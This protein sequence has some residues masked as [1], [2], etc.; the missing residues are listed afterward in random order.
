MRTD[1]LQV[2][3]S[4]LND[5]QE[6]LS[7]KLVAKKGV[8]FYIIPVMNISYF[9]CENR[10]TYLKDLSG[11]K[12][13]IEKPLIELESDLGKLQFL[14]VAKNILLNINHILK[15]KSLEAGK[16]EVFTIDNSPIIVS[17]FYAAT[18]RKLFR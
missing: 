14:R 15:F 3:K 8:E 7:T 1:F 18:F 6:A 4:S 11:N 13:I 12:F 17:Q 5:W 16:I 9:Y 10:I 2:N